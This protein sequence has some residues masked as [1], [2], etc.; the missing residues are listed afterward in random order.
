MRTFDKSDIALKAPLG[1]ARDAIINLT[2]WSNAAILPSAP[3]FEAPLG[4]ARR[5]E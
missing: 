2:K 4:S 1:N 5:A 3:N